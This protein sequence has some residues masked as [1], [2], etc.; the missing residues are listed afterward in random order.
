MKLT[1]KQIN[2]IIYALEDEISDA[3]G[4]EK[5]IEELVELLKNLPVDLNDNF[6]SFTGFKP[7]DIVL[8]GHEIKG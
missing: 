2:L 1:V 3:P 7:T 8:T 4:D 5:D 6:A